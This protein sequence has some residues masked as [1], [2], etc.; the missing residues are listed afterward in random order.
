MKARK[1]F[2]LPHTVAYRTHLCHFYVYFYSIC[3]NVFPLLY[4][5]FQTTEL[6]ISNCFGR[7]GT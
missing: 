7:S 3:D 1:M 6:L 4:V 5:S 2:I